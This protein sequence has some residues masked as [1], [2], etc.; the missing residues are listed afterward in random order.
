M[1]SSGPGAGLELGSCS[2]VPGFTTDFYLQLPSCP[3]CICLICA[4]GAVS[5]LYVLEIQHIRLSVKK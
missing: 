1:W 4:E 3:P 5:S 2:I